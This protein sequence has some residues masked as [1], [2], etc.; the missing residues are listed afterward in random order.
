M[1]FV[2]ALKDI[3]EGIVIVLVNWDGIHIIFHV[4]RLVPRIL[5]FTWNKILVCNHVLNLH[6]L[7]IT[8]AISVLCIVNLARILDV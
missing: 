1:E 8:N 4:L 3:M 2:F 5:Y 7:K 6:M